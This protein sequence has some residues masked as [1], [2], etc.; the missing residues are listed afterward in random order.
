MTRNLLYTAVTRARRQVLI[1][2]RWDSVM[3]MV[4]NKRM[5]RRY[6]AMGI[7]MAEL[8]PLLLEEHDV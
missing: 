3:Q 7:R 8:A 4:E 6:S 5:R 1:V 2:G